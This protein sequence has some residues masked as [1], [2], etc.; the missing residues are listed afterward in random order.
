MSVL[1][2][3]K[4]G[5]K[6]TSVPKLPK[7]VFEVDVNNHELL[8]LAY[9]AYLA[10]G[11]DNIAKTKDRSEVRGG[12]RKPWKQKGTGRAR[13]GSI[14]SPIWR[15]GGVT[16]GPQGN[17]NY[18]K[19]IS[20]KAKRKATRQAL[21][22]AARD[23]EL[24]IIESIEVKDGKT[25]TAANLLAKMG[26]D[27]KTVVVVSDKTPEIVRAFNNLPYAQ[28]VTANYLNVFTLLNAH[29]IIM[30]KDAVKAVDGWLGGSDE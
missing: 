13:H 18:S 23:G 28:V 17:E 20:K 14:R 16:F 19:K 24:K 3:S 7:D 11:R 10:N 8:K 6:S 30:T 26:C 5:A 27:R 25:R 2:F 12:G 9:E 1:A 22:M 15:T 4:S 29:N 21:T